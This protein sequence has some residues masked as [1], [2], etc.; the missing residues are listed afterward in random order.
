MS[1]KILHHA[2]LQKEIDLTFRMI[3]GVTAISMPPLWTGYIA[4]NSVNDNARILVY[5][6]ELENVWEYWQQLRWYVQID[7]EIGKDFLNIDWCPTYLCV[8]H[9]W[10]YWSIYF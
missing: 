3:C 8:S 4:S 9:Q 10:I 5:N 6:Q 7:I 1:I 2:I